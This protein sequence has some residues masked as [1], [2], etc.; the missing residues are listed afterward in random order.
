VALDDGLIVPVV[1]NAD[2][3]DLA[4]LGQE[5]AELAERARRGQL[6]SAETEGGCFSVTN[7][8]AYRIDAFTPL[9][10]PPQTAILGVGRARAHP[11]V[12]DGAIAVRTLLV[13]SLTF[14]HQ[15]VDGAPA[16]AFLDAVVGLLEDPD[17]L[18]G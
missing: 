9:L 13:L 1:R 5:I 4:T 2:G 14:D 11:A 7:L 10:N 15:V 6:A 12:V 16:A 3:K 18:A 17:R 8:G